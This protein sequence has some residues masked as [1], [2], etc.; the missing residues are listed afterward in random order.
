MILCCKKCARVGLVILAAYFC[1]SCK[2][3]IEYNCVLIKVDWLTACIA[4]R[5]VDAV[6]IVFLRRWRKICTILQP[7]G[8]SKSRYPK[9]CPESC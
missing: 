4:L 9:K 2:S 8:G 3:Q 6:L 1:Y 5:V 7:K